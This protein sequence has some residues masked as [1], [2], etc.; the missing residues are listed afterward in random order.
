MN[1]LKT[2]PKTH[3][4]LR[5]ILLSYGI[6][7]IGPS[8]CAD[9]H[10]QLIIFVQ[11]GKSDVDRSFQG[12]VPELARIAE[13]N[14]VEFKLVNI[15]KEGAPSE[16]TITPLIVFQNHLGRLIYQG[17]TTTLERV[18][19]FIRTSRYV[20]QGKVLNKRAD[21]PIRKIAR[22]RV[23]APLK[24]APVTGATPKDYNHSHFESKS[25]KA[26]TTGFTQ[27]HLEKRAELNRTD[28]GFYFDFYPWLSDDGTLFLSLAVFSQFHCKKPVFELKKDPITG[29]WDQRENLFRKAAGILEQAVAKSI[30][31]ISYG[32]GFDSV[33]PEIQQ[34]TWDEMGLTLPVAIDQK[35]VS[36]PANFTL[37]FSWILDDSATRDPPMIQFRFPP[38]LDN[39]SGTATRGRAEFQLGGPKKIEGASGF[40][41]VDP[42]G[43]AMGEADLDDALQGSLFLH[44][45]KFP[46]AT[47]KIL[48][49]AGDGQDLA[50]SQVSP[51][52]AT[53]TF[54]LKG[55]SIPLSPSMELEPIL[56]RDGKVRL[57]VRGEFEIN[58]R[59]FE[60]EEAE[61]PEPAN[62][63]LIISYHFVMKPKAK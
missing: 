38:P 3:K 22:T 23:W 9:H 52:N 2:K 4:I 46:V 11:S 58:V 45:K 57:L 36:I 55:K 48:S 33:G 59:N 12:Q 60:I 53:G 31:D 34:K 18:G 6:T 19:N 47:F 5:A 7:F 13:K 43:V 41:E 17:R 39:Y 14:Q 40:F 50:F 20:P 27:F 29:P 15:A 61:G 26:L 63:T 49:I 25:I 44:T 24:I 1:L 42:T 32:D 37:P 28:R 62:H 54:T 8:L 56:N 21:I 35:S 10:E 51:V 16:V 30:S